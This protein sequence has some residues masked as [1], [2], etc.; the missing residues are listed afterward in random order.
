MWR[1]DVRAGRTGREADR[2]ALVVTVQEAATL[3]LQRAQA[4]EVLSRN[5]RPYSVSTLLNYETQLGFT[6][7]GSARVLD[8]PIVREGAAR[9]G[10]VP[11][12]RLTTRVVQAVENQLAARC[13]SETTRYAVAALRAV[14][15]DAYA[16]DLTDVELG[17]VKLPSPGK[18]KQRVLTGAEAA[19]LLE[20]ARIDDEAR[21]RSFA[22]PLLVLLADTGMRIGEA[23]SL[24]WGPRGVVAEGSE[25][26]VRVE[27]SKT[28]AGV[29]VVA[30]EFETARTLRS[31]RS[32]TVRPDDGGLVFTRADGAGLDPRGAPR[33]MLA[34]VTKAAGVEGV[35]FHTF[36]HTHVTELMLSAPA[37]AVSGRV[38][39]RSV[40]FTLQRYAK[41]TPESQERIFEAIRK[42]RA[43]AG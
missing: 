12:S 40:A 37:Q 4:G 41:A 21:G 39:H 34:R 29:R 9:L 6:P 33:A 30:L 11:V 22:V 31:H 7:G 25:P 15:R 5:G 8:L 35:T 26:S 1:D 27:R 24:V 20:A 43:Q 28:D 19:Q 36:R 17:T 3:F 18:P 23:L 10:D 13:G 2:T 14:H 42:R 38:G 16:R 32:A